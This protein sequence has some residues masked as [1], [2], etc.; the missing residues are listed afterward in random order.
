[1]GAYKDADGNWKIDFDP[2]KNEGERQ[3][4]ISANAALDRINA[5]NTEKDLAADIA[6]S[7]AVGQ[8]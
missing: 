8:N 6:G 7:R 1:M 5:A 2:P 3:N 4:Q